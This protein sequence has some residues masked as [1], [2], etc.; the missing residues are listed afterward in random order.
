MQVPQA[1]DFGKILNLT[2]LINE[3]LSDPKIISMRINLKHRQVL[4]Y[5]QAG[6]ILGFLEKQDKFFSL[7]PIGKVFASSSVNRKE[8][9][10]NALKKVPIINEVLKYAYTNKGKIN[11]NEIT[12]IIINHSGLSI[13]TAKRRTNSIFNWL[14]W[15]SYHFPSFCH[16]DGDYLKV[17]YTNGKSQS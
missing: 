9:A 4:Y 14:Y 11:K 5:L 10:F 6:E 15:I 13:S 7:T 16:C 17:Y 2:L 12:S 8:V 1:D 3:G